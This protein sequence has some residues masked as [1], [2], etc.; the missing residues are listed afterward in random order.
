MKDSVEQQNRSVETNL[1]LRVCAAALYLHCHKALTSAAEGRVAAEA[2]FIIIAHL[3]GLVGLFADEPNGWVISGKATE[4]NRV[5][6]E[7]CAAPLTATELESSASVICHRHFQAKPWKL[8][9][10]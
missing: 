8:F 5:S 6:V 9:Q 1:H 3:R 10:F 4:L 7:P 2:N